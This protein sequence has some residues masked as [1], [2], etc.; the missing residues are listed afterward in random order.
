MSNTIISFIKDGTIRKYPL[1]KLWRNRKSSYLY[2]S[3]WERSFKEKRPVTLE[4]EPIPWL[5]L[6]MVKLLE[7]R[8]RD[9]HTVFE[10]GSGNS[11]L[12]FTSRVWQVVSIEY[13]EK[14]KQEIQG[15]INSPKVQIYYFDY[16]DPEYVNSIRSLS[17]DRYSIVLIDGRNRVECCKAAVSKLK[18][19]GVILLDDSHR[20]R[21]REGYDFVLAKGF[22]KL[23]FWGMGPGSIG[24][25]CTTVFYR[26]NNCLDI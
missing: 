22:K 1:L 5:S 16:R 24:L 2:L 17:E 9:T 11:T 8:L 25:K 19:D 3:G 6:P 23:D 7:E 13:D 18:D 12:F 21:Y 4:G 10:Y 20:P 26:P 15:Q 14:W